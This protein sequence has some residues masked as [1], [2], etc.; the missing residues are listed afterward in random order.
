MN[1]RHQNYQLNS[2]KILTLLVL[3]LLLLTFT[4]CKS[5][6]PAAGQTKPGEKVEPKA[7]K[8]VK[9]S[10]MPMGEGVKV[11]G[12]LAAFEQ[13]TVSV[14]A[15]GRIEAIF[16]DL[17]SVIKKGQQIARIESKDYQFRVQ[18]S[19]AS[20]AQ[21][22][23]RVGLSPDGKDDNVDPEETATVRQTKALMEEARLVKE[24]ASQLVKDGVI[25]KAEYD[26]SVASYKVAE[27]RY[28]DSIEEIRNRLALL[29]Q[30]RSELAIAKAQL[31][32][33]II[34][35][36]IDGKVQEKRANLGEYLTSGSPVVTIVKINPLRF[37]AEVPEREVVNIR[38]GQNVRLS[39][40]GAETNY[41]G[42]ITR[43]S[44]TITE[45]NRVLVV[46]ADII[47]DGSLRPGSFARAEIVT[48]DSSMGL[49][50]PLNA[51]VT[52]AGIEKVIVAQ[53]GKAAEKPVTTGR[54]V[55]DY[56]EIISGVSLGDSVVI[57]PGNL[58]SGQPVN[59]TE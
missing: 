24:R 58:Q 10:E 25:S 18:Q 53:N 2:I 39:I 48:D 51:L 37:R 12:T 56:V 20:L 41:S 54:R 34:Y 29:A 13:T 11:N 28:Q 26:S 9:V 57:N 33:T 44:P 4:A 8:V 15:P 47:N 21:A 42:R 16:F 31:A 6:Y 17:G 1:Y 27:G 19:E 23:A 3:S 35:S 38:I 40:D 45:Q 7:V 50:V 43:L 5:G 36:P 52:F 30:R 59:V 55:G 32:D 49:T 46:E 14:K 22:R